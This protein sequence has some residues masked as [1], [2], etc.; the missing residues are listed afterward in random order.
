MYMGVT[1]HPHESGVMLHLPTVS[2][3]KSMDGVLRHILL[4]CSILIIC[5]ILLA[6]NHFGHSTPS[7]KERGRGIFSG[8][9]C[10]TPSQINETAPTGPV[11]MH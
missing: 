9:V 3:L 8:F 1:G 11:Y 4:L 5:P 10:G 7:P 6:M 2:A